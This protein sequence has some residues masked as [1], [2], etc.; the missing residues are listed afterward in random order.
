[1]GLG[2]LWSKRERQR[3]VQDAREA[4]EAQL[5]HHVHAIPPAS[6]HETFGGICATA[7][8]GATVELHFWRMNNDEEADNRY[9]LL[10]NG[11]PVSIDGDKLAPLYHTLA[12]RVTRV[13]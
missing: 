10:V 3:E 11:E 9:R 2:W 12:N 1:M 5:L 7:N 13:L 8:C 6:W 4:V